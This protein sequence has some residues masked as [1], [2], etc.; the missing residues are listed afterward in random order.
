MSA[1]EE[2]WLGFWMPLA[3]VC[4]SIGF[5]LTDRKDWRHKFAVIAFLLAIV[6]LGLHGSTTRGADSSETA[7]LAAL[8][9]MMGP[10]AVM[11]LG[12]LIAIFSGPSPVGPLP[13]GLRPMGFILAYSGLIWIGWILVSHPSSAISNGIGETI[14]STWVN[15]FLSVL[16]LIAA[17]AGS[18]CVMMG[19]KR[20][21]EATTLA[22]L[23]IVGGYMFWIIMRDG[24]AGLDA[25]GWHEI[26]WNQMMLVIGGLMGMIAALIGFVYLV[27][28][29]ERRE[30]DPDVVAPLSEEEKSVVDAVLRMH[31]GNSED[32]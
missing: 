2:P 24:S 22:T 27:V 8:L 10:V 28:M 23:T 5:W 12:S 6:I 9:R 19:E 15:V 14:W 25:A 17:L 32:E 21:K 1:L 30:P 4:L 29:A 13:K 26:H 16:I 11:V 20:H 3:M 7:L 31:L 18:F